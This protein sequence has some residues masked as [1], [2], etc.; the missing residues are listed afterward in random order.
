MLLRFSESNTRGEIIMTTEISDG[1][2][3]AVG[4][5][6]LIL[7]AV[8]VVLYIITA[9][10]YS[11]MFKKAGEPGWKGLVPFYNQYILYKLSWRTNMFF[12]WL[13]LEIAFAVLNRLRGDNPIL[14]LIAIVVGIAG[15]VINAKSCGRVSKAYGRGLGTA[16]GLFF[17]P[18]IFSWI[19]GLGSAQ[20]TAPTEE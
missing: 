11:K 6:G 3:F 18:V 13:V 5:I 10:G 15:I 17:L 2:A 12:I 16:V 9:L 4:A 7:T 1:V 20:Y 14:S 19:L 8:I